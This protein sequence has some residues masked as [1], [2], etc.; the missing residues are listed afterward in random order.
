MHPGVPSPPPCLSLLL[1]QPPTAGPGKG[2]S[3][4]EVRRTDRKRCPQPSISTPTPT[5]Q[6]HPL[7]PGVHD[8][9]PEEAGGGTPRKAPA[10]SQLEQ[11][12]KNTVTS[13]PVVVVTRPWAQRPSRRCPLR[14]AASPSAAHC[15]G[16]GRAAPMPCP[17]STSIAPGRA[18]W[19]A[20]KP[21]LQLCSRP[22]RAGFRS[23][24]LRRL[25]FLP[26][27][28]PHRGAHRKG[29]TS[30][31]F[32]YFP[33][34]LYSRAP[35]QRGQGDNGPAVGLRFHLTGSP[36]PPDACTP[37]RLG[38]HLPAPAT[39]ANSGSTAPTWQRG[40]TR[41]DWGRNPDIQR[42]GG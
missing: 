12:K 3:D 13:S 27:Y 14:Q 5:R 32:C 30:P 10:C 7:R 20:R 23:R 1:P 36:T 34:P 24:P 21:G 18:H 38:P 9:A 33:G 37:V 31:S 8:T 35:L 22:Q 17:L 26:R 19:S 16:S 28:L 41:C 39:S 11:Q 2:A 29:K 25:H 4:G 15:G 6:P 42:P 40:A